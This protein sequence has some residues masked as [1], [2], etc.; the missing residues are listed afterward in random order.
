MRFVLKLSA[1]DK[2]ML[3]GDFGEFKQKA[4]EFIV[5]YANVL[6]AEE[7]CDVSRATLFVG[8]QHYLDCYPE[9][10]DYRDIFSQ[11][12]LCSDKRIEPGEMERTCDT[13]TCGACC[14][15][16]DFVR[17]RVSPEQHAKNRRFLDE[18]LKMGVKIVDSCTPYFVGW[19]PL[20]GEHF[21]TTESSNVVI[22]NTVFGAY[23]NSDGVEAA[24]C[25]AIT[26]RTPLWGMHIKENRYATCLFRLDFEVETK[27]DYDILGFTLGRLLPKGGVPAL[28]GPLLRP[29]IQKLR[30]LC[31]SIAVTSAAEICHIIG[32]TPEAQTR[33]MAFGGK[34]PQYEIQVTREEFEKSYS[35]LCDGGTG[36]VDFVSVGCPH[37][38]L[39]EIQNIARYLKGKKVSPKAELQIWT[40]YATKSM[41]NVNGYTEV[42]EKSGASLLTGSCPLL[43]QKE[44]H[45]HATAMAINGAKQAWSIRHQTDIPVY[46]GDIRQCIDSAITGK[47]EGKKY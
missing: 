16:K 36:P 14:D 12:Y 4:M 6:G 25:A 35:M 27:R 5:R 37:L 40:D 32:L 29:D 46:F 22:S 15:L 9:G 20:M 30:Q 41:A 17:S 28:T 8:A 10:T 3:N 26:G 19:V 7:L 1:R 47:W 39:Y 31:A 23:G 24:V 38:T 34:S 43:M 13:Q 44:S 11:F 18:T 45:K 2:N 33:E 21:V 42:I